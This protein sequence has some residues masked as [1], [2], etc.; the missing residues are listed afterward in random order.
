[1]T[2]E[3]L[4]LII[5]YF[6]ACS[7]FHSHPKNMIN[8]KMKEVKF[9]DFIVSGFMNRFNIGGRSYRTKNACCCVCRAVW[10]AFGATIYGQS[11]DAI[12]KKKKKAYT[13]NRWVSH[14]FA[15]RWW[16]FQ[17][18]S[19]SHNTINVLLLYAYHQSSWH[20]EHWSVHMY[21]S[22]PLCSAFEC[23]IVSWQ[24][25]CIDWLLSP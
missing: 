12:Q 25:E 1:M 9:F 3:I 11:W 2:K 18:S 15:L 23:S 8:S 19:R 20:N 17:V 10:V 4:S 21:L 16:T 7:L 13:L 22:Y 14:G 5:L 6:A 24:N